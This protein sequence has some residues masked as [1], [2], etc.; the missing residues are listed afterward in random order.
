MYSFGIGGLLRFE[1]KL[2]NWSKVA[3]EIHIFDP[4]ARRWKAPKIKG[5]NIHELGIASKNMEKTKF[6]AYTSLVEHFEHHKRTVNVLQ[7]DVKGTEKDVLPEIAA[8]PVH[9]RPQKILVEGHWW[10]SSAIRVFDN[11]LLALRKAGYAMFH[12]EPNYYDDCCTEFLSYRLW[13][14]HSFELSSSLCCI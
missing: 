2:L 5:L 6:K 11:I 9:Q 8:L 13:P 14:G 12:M 1:T 4:G 7:I 3:C 10:G